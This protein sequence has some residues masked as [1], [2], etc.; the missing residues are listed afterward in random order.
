MESKESSP[1]LGRKDTEAAPP[2]SYDRKPLVSLL[3]MEFVIWIV[4]AVLAASRFW[5]TLLRHRDT[6]ILKIVPDYYLDIVFACLILVFPLCYKV[7]FGLY[8]LQ[9]VRYVRQALRTREGTGDAEL[10]P[11]S[12]EVEE[13]VGNRLIKMDDSHP[14]LAHL[15]DESRRL[16][17]NL[18]TRSGVYLIIGVL[19][20]FSGLLFFYL[21]SLNLV[22]SDVS[23]V[24]QITVLAPRFGILFF[25]EFIAFFF[26]RQY[27]AAMEEFRYYEAIKRQREET[28]ALLGMLKPEERERHLL[29]LVKQ[30]VFY[31]SAGKLSAGET[32]EIIESKKLTKDEIVVFEKIIEALGR[33]R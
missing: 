32:T 16:S 5:I 1:H 10:L 28:L 4:F 6:D 20:A 24:S 19:V 25:I 11:R 29:D 23:F 30:G 8:P 12:I 26:L 9:R 3:A 7:V 14:L 17:A 15:A 2:S 33:P 27:Q 21:Q 13:A 31:S 18:Y 22:A